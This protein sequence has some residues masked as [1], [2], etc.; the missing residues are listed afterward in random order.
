M[1][2]HDYIQKIK[3]VVG[4]EESHDIAILLTVILVGIGSFFI[5]RWSKTTEKQRVTDYSIQSGDLLIKEVTVTQNESQIGDF[6]ASRNGAKYYPIGC[7]GINRIKED[8]KVYF[9]T[10]AEAQA[11]GLTKSST[12]K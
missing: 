10:E 7:S 5:G 1:S 9:R 6:V 8:N 12:C 4:G 3:R 2:I 11:S